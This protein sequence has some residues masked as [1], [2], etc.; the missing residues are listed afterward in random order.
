MNQMEI[1][2]E[3]TIVVSGIHYTLFTEYVGN[4]T[5][6]E[7][8][9]YSLIMVM[10]FGFV[11]NALVYSRDAAVFLYLVPIRQWNWFFHTIGYE[12]RMTYVTKKALV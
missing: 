6:R 2:N 5:M 8:A 3:G 11:V 10:M 7:Y 1:F 9:G 4:A 12:N